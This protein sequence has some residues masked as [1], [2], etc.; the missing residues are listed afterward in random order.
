MAASEKMPGTVKQ[1]KV[2]AETFELISLDGIKCKPTSAE[3]HL[4]KLIL[5]L[6]NNMY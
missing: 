3:M 1:S 5:R 4:K 2:T 6:Y